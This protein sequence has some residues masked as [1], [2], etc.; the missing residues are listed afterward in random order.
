Q[1]E[2]LL[3]RRMRLGA[4]SVANI[5]TLTIQAGLT[6]A[7]AWG[8]FGYWA[9]G[10]GQI[11]SSLCF[12]VCVWTLCPWRPGRP[13]GFSSVRAHLP[14]GGPVTGFTV[15]NY[16]SRNLDNL[17]IGRLWGSVQLGFY[18]RAYQLLLLPL[19]WILEPLSSVAIPALSRLNGSPTRYRE[20]Y[21]RLL[22]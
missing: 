4:L 14:F 13:A 18:A 3:R 7:L 16:F 12:A 19:D 5:V 9:L 10:Y 2:A 22:E 21:L 20:A 8:G 1:H 15:M 11:G 6:V 17:L